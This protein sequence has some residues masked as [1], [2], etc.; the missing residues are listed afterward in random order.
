MVKDNSLTATKANVK[1]LDGM[2]AMGQGNI[3]L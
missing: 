1:A 3:A 2:P